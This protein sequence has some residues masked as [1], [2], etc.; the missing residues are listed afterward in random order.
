MPMAVC[1]L[2][3]GRWCRW[4]VPLQSF[5]KIC[6]AACALVL[7]PVQRV[8]PGMQQYNM[9]MLRH[10]CRCRAPAH[11]MMSKPSY[12]YEQYVTK[13]KIMPRLEIL[14]AS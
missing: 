7:A 8:T 4:R 1:A 14:W 6:M 5:G 2:K 13:G 10:K 12:V 3:L 11:A 9:S